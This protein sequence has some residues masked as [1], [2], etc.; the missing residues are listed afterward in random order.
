MIKKFLTEFNN[1][2][3]NKIERFIWNW[4]FHLIK[5]LNL[6]NNFVI[7]FRIIHLFLYLLQIC[8]RGSSVFYRIYFENEKISKY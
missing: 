3:I 2:L 4:M 6:F 5:I 1:F 7:I 8:N